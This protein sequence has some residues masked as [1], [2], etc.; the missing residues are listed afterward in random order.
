MPYKKLKPKRSHLQSLMVNAK[1]IAQKLVTSDLMVLK[2]V[3]FLA[4]QVTLTAQMVQW[5]ER[6]PL[7]L[8]DRFDF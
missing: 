5:L 3:S 4:S 6:L 2:L 7:E 8:S 1:L